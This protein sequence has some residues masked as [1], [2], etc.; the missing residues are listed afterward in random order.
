VPES[1]ELWKVLGFESL[2]F[3]DEFAERPGMGLQRLSKPNTFCNS[4]QA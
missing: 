1:I 3:M 2:K 4:Y